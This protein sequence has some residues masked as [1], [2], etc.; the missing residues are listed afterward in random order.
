M[1]AVLIF[2]A[3][4]AVCTILSFVLAHDSERHGQ[5]CSVRNDPDQAV[6]EV[7][8]KNVKNVFLDCDGLPL[9]EYKKRR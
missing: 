8:T 7:Y 4:V 6:I 3:I 9:E 2:L 1:S 5:I